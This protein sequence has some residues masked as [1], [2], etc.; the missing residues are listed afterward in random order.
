MLLHS[1]ISGSPDFKLLKGYN[2]FLKQKGLAF[3]HTQTNTALHSEQL[4]AF[5]TECE[6]GKNTAGIILGCINEI[7]HLLQRVS[8]LQTYTLWACL[9]LARKSVNEE[10]EILS[11]VLPKDMTSQTITRPKNSKVSSCRHRK[12]R[13]CQYPALFKSKIHYIYV[14]LRAFWRQLATEVRQRWTGGRVGRCKLLAP[15]NGQ[16]T[17]TKLYSISWYKSYIVY[18]CNYI[19]IF[20]P[21]L[22]VRMAESLLHGGDYANTADWPYFN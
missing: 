14:S 3:T 17:S 12:P 6:S 4:L 21:T 9:F 1:Y 10:Q 8:R 5:W 22:S 11:L 20:I 2:F 13:S 16:T 7:Y 18:I 19:C 15:R